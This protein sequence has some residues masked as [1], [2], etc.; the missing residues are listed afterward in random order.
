MSKCAICHVCDQIDS[1][2]YIN[3]NRKR[4]IKLQKY[5]K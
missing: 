3:M 2:I 1:Y 4:Y 5:N